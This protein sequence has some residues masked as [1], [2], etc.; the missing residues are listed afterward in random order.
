MRQTEYFRALL[1]RCLGHFE[2]RFFL[3]RL[4]SQAEVGQWRID[5]PRPREYAEMAVENALSNDYL[6]L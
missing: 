3:R 4:C 2:E 5:L 6:L 1:C